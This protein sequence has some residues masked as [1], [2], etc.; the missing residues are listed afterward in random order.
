[1]KKRK[2]KV[3][4][5]IESIEQLVACEWVFFNGRAKHISVL[6]NMMLK[7]VLGYIKGGYLYETIRLTNAEYYSEKQQEKLLQTMGDKLCYYCPLDETKKGVHGTP[8]GPAGCEGS[9]C[10]EAF[11]I[12]L[13][14]EVE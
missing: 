14:E 5:R 12:F 3:G 1:M 11:E 6:R 10:E 4:K 7:V 2:F 8:N 9:H 13:E